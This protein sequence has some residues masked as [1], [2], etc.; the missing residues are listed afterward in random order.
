[1]WR[2]LQQAEPDDYVIATGRTVSVRA[3]VEWSFKAVGIDILWKGEK[4]KEVGW[5][6]NV[7]GT[8]RVP[9]VR[10][11]PKYYR[12]TEVERLLGN[13]AKAKRVLGWEATTPVEALCKEMVEA[14]VKLVK[15]GD[16]ES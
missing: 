15:A 4:E 6:R 13:P 5:G 9:M 14:D 11:D 1:M 12:P 2:I 3:F 7:T 10:I 8:G 16:F